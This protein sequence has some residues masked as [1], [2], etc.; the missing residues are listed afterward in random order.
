[1]HLQ[2]GHVNQKAGPDE[3]IMESVLSQYVAD[4]LAKKALD[5]FPKLLHAVD[6][7]LR[8][9]PGAIGGIR[10]AWLEG[11]NLFLNAKVPGNIGHQI[12]QKRKGLEWLDGD[13]LF[14]RAVSQKPQ[15]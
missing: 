9:P 5:A 12:L 6:I 3:L 11:F 15:T 13:R 7:R 1:M 2:L 10:R 14:E 8:H 4:V